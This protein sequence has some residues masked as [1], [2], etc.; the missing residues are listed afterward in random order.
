MHLHRNPRHHPHQMAAPI[1]RSAVMRVLNALMAPMAATALAT[2]LGIIASPPHAGRPLSVDDAGLNDAGNGHIEVWWEGARGQRGTVYA[3]PAY[4]PIEGIE[5]AA[6]LARD[7]QEHHTLQGLQAKWQWSPS[8]SQGCNTASSAGVSHRL[9]SSGNTL[10]LNAIGSCANDWGNVHANLGAQR[11]PGQPWHPTWGL[12]LEKAW[13]AVTAHV[14]AFG[15]RHNAP[16]FQTGVR[17]EWEPQG[18]KWQ[19]DGTVG[20]QSGHTLLSVGFK[21][22]F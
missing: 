1:A 19:I 6:V 22:G 4:A 15:E 8:Q 17:W 18:Q 16:T 13:G 3:A 21:R 5:V 10:A 9:G 7:A 12:A 14:E 11:A 2:T 20:R